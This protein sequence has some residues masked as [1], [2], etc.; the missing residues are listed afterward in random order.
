MADIDF[1]EEK[2]NQELKGTATLVD[3]WAPW[4]GPCI[5]LSDHIEEIHK[6]YGD[7]INVVKVNTEQGNGREIFI[8]YAQPL[9]VNGIPF[10]LFFN[11]EGKMVKHVLGAYVDKI[12]ECAAEIVNNG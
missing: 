6:K 4:C 8:H 12:K 11:K 2:T 9:G 1:L 7:K 3:I 5:F 10:I